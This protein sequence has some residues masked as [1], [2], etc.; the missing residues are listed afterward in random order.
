MGKD[1]KKGL[2]MGLGALFGEEYP[3]AQPE[4]EERAPDLLPIE[5]IE[6][7]ADQPRKRF[8][9]EALELLAESIRTYGLIQPITVRPLDSGFYQI[10]AGERRWRA[11]RMAGLDRVPLDYI[12]AHG[13][14]LHNA[15]GVYSVPMA[16]FAVC[17]ILQLYKQSRF[18]AANQ[19][20]HK[21]EK[22]R[23]L[24]ELSGKRVCIL[25]CAVNGSTAFD[26]ALFAIASG[27]V[28]ID[29]SSFDDG[30]YYP[31]L[32]AEGFEGRAVTSAGEE[33]TADMLVSM[34]RAEAVYDGP[35]GSVPTPEI[36]L[37]ASVNAEGERVVHVK[38]VD[39]LLAAIAPDTT[40]YLDSDFYDL[41][42]AADYGGAGGYWYGWLNNYD[43]P[44]LIISGVEN[45]TIISENGAT[46]S[47]VPRY[48]DVI[49][50]SGCTGITLR[51]VTAGHTEEP[52]ECSGGVLNFQRCNDILIDACRLYGCGIVGVSASD[53]SSL[54][55]KDTEIYE[56]SNAAVTLW[57]VSGAVFDNCNIYNCG[58]PE[59]VLTDSSTTYNGTALKSLDYSLENGVPVE[60]V[61]PGIH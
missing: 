29:D 25:G 58:T 18:F 61:Y 24:L 36:A 57:S 41:S 46:I 54:T 4:H 31:L 23:G 7:R 51:G 50:F 47:A 26:N 52:G 45:L 28:T 33:I 13:I 15:A 60:Y 42:A 14:E 44:G 20:Q 59:L 56:C 40:I 2:G 12:R 8:D 37:D 3:T 30:L 22:H 27:E 55:V 32:Y 19:A 10:I 21:W 5:K 48:A 6:P 17:G 1:G 9:P 49:Q 43:G 16:E 39:E 34:Q 38:T 35:D 11:A 53:S